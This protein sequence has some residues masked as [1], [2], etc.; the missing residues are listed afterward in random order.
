MPTLS[1]RMIATKLKE[2]KWNKAIAPAIHVTCNAAGM[3]KNLLVLYFLTPG[4]SRYWCKQLVIPPRKHSHCLIS[5]W[6]CLQLLYW[7]ITTYKHRLF[8]VKIGV[9]FS[10]ISALYTK[11]NLLPTCLLASTSCSGN[12]CQIFFTS[13]KLSRIMMTS[14]S[15][16]RQVSRVYASLHW[17][18]L[19]KC[20]FKIS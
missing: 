13:W 7:W 1:Y 18:K 17:Q 6:G 3:T 14:K 12:S 8:W 11:K 5:E 10:L 9:P 19:Q 2:Q 16:T 4:I 20:W 15:Y